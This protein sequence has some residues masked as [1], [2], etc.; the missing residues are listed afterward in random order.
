MGVE[1]HA[2]SR[3]PAFANI[4][5]RLAYGTMGKDKIQLQLRSGPAES[6]IYAVH[7]RALSSS[8]AATSCGQNYLGLGSLH[9]LSLPSH[10]RR[11]SP[12]H[13][14]PHFSR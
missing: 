5:L 13:F 6:L 8:T 7:Q 3:N 9:S 11:L 10:W 1:I 12:P 4:A 14:V 2:I